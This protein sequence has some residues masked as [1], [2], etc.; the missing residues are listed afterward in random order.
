V[1]DADIDRLAL[2]PEPDRAAQASALS[3]HEIS[4]SQSS[5]AVLIGVSSFFLILRSGVFDASR[6]DEAPSW[7]ETVQ[8][9][10]LTM[11]AQ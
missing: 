2:S 1:A 10:L 7:F 6:K 5:K 8:E 4:T 3:D 9:R 11:R